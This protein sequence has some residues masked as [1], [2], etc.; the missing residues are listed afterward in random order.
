MR[1]WHAAAPER[2]RH[3]RWVSRQIESREFYGPSERLQ[4]L[5]YADPYMGRRFVEFSWAI[6]PDQLSRPNEPRRLMSRAFYQWLPVEV[7][8]R[9]SKGDV[10]TPFIASL[11]RAAGQLLAESRPLRLVERGYVEGA[12]VHDQLHRCKD[13]RPCQM[14][15]LAQIVALELWIRHH[16]GKSFR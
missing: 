1:T 15:H 8:T 5:Y 6:P 13:A 3:L 11:Q 2:R 9:D 12:V 4:H 14:N 7:A 10:M 16:E